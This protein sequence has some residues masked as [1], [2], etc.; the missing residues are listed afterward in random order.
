MS[1]YPYKKLLSQ[2]IWA[3]VSCT[4]SGNYQDTKIQISMNIKQVARAVV[5]QA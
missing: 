3:Q 2:L 1:E 4:D 5:E